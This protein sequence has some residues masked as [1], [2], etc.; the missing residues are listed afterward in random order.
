MFVGVG[1]G[2]KEIG[3]AAVRIETDD[4]LGVGDEIGE[5]VH[6]VIEKT[7]GGVVD[8]VFDAAD[9][10]SSEMHDALNGGDDFAR[11]FVSFD[12]EAVSTDG[13]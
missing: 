13:L 11:R 5:C 7:A 2:D 8:D 1:F 6:V 9:F 3:E 4:A 10:D 12:G